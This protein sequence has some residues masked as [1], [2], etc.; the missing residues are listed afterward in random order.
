MSYFSLT[1]FIKDEQLD[2]PQVKERSIIPK[3]KTWIDELDKV[4]S[5]VGFPIKITDS[6][7]FGQGSSQHYFNGSGAIDLRPSLTN[8]DSFNRLLL[9][10]YANPN[11]NR[12]CYYPPGELF[13]FGG[14]HIDKKYRG[15][16][17]F[18]SDRD[19]VDW[20]HI[21]LYDIVKIIE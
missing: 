14:F 17:L 6:V 16:H 21:E 12:I 11:I 19:K 9:A 8:Y 10:L 7:R 20:E 3:I 5:L 1:E 18:I 15:K 13:A 4:R 2:H